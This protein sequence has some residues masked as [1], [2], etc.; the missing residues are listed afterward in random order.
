MKL[1]MMSMARLELGEVALPMQFGEKLNPGLIKRAFYAIASNKRQPYGVDPRA[2]KKASVWMSR[3]R[4]DYR[5]SYGKGMSRVPRKV[6]SRRGT[7]INFTAAFAPGTVKGRKA[8][9][10]K[11]ERIWE[12]KIN[13]KERRKAIR[14][15]I[16]ATIMPDLVAAR[17]H[18]VPKDYPFIIEDK[19]TESKKTKDVFTV[20]K[21]LGFADELTRSSIKKV[22][23]GKGKMRGRKYQRK[24][25]PL[26]VVKDRCSLEKSA[27]NIA[28]VDVVAVSDLNVE[29][30]APGASPGRLT[31]W[32]KGA[33][34]ALAERGMFK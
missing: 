11:A 25:G 14:S 21:A 29:L 18:K 30:L 24:T 16:A 26:L 1:K 22:R 13:T 27:A 17:G 19:I 23:A 9:P 28:G 20:L 8:H 7:Q 4:R 12:R 32:T 3:R 6:M 34:D 15:A 2:G 31:L 5:G 33:I 10:P